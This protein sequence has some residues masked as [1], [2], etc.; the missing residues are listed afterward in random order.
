MRRLCTLIIAT[1]PFF[2]CASESVTD[3]HS[4]EL[5]VECRKSS[6]RGCTASAPVCANAPSGRYFAVQSVSGSDAGSYSPGHAPVCGI[7]STGAEG[8]S[9][10]GLLA[11]TSMCANLHA[12]SG[13]GISNIGKVFYAKCRY[14]AVTYPIPE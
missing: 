2:A 1:L 13:S 7:A 3:S 10:G 9:I 6:D 8:V 12:E 11:P 4:F 14:T 5:R